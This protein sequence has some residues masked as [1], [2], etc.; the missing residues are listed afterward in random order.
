MLHFN[1]GS[2]YAQSSWR[3]RVS[4]YREVS[5]LL[6]YWSVIRGHCGAAVDPLFQCAVD[7]FVV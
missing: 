5:E 7:A 3:T 6:A 2:L 4:A 1:C